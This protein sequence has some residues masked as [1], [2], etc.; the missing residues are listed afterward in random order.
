[1][2]ARSSCCRWCLLSIDATTGGTN[3]RNYQ[4]SAT[5]G[6]ASVVC[7]LRFRNQTLECRIYKISFWKVSNAIHLCF[8]LSKMRNS[9][10]CGIVHSKIKCMHKVYI[11]SLRLLTSLWLPMNKLSLT[12]CKPSH[13]LYS[14]PKYLH[15]REG[16]RS[17]TQTH[18]RCASYL[19]CLTQAPS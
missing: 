4:S 6:S 10:I 12:S 18:S 17:P 19:L 14:N 8:R 11:K 2:F 1:M 16:N 5:S 7:H 3:Q 13:M 15:Q 9:M